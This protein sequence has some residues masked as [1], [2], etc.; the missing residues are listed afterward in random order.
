MAKTI[1]DIVGSTI[2]DFVVIH[3]YTQI[4]MNKVIINI[5][6]PLKY[7]TKNEGQMTLMNVQG[8]D[9]IN[10]TV[11]TVDF[12]AEEYFRIELDHKKTLEISLLAE[13]YNGPEAISI[14]YKTGEIIA[15]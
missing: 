7:Y 9:L 13:D 8:K 2:Q 1:N 4:I 11:T 12:K 14:H 6:S 15:I 3:D 5:Y 10:T